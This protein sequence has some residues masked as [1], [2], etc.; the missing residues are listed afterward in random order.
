[1]RRVFPFI[2]TV[3]T[4]CLVRLLPV[5]SLSPWVL[6]AAVLLLMIPPSRHA[7]QMWRGPDVG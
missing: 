1:M 5:D 4:F 3:P 7:A 6:V 2:V